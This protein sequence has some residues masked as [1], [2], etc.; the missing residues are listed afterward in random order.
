MNKNICISIPLIVFCI[1]LNTGHVQFGKIFDLLVLYFVVRTFWTNF[2]FESSSDWS[3]LVFLTL[4]QILPWSRAGCRVESVTMV[5]HTE[6][7][8]TSFQRQKTEFPQTKP[9]LS[10]N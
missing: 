3:M 10:P 6:L 1:F 9:E 2:I 4:N 7:N 5:I 8:Q